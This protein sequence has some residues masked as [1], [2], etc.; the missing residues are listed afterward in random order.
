MPQEKLYETF[1][2][3]KT[4]D[5]Y[6]YS[7]KF[8]KWLKKTPIPNTKIHEKGIN[9]ECTYLQ[10][11]VSG[12]GSIPLHRF[13]FVWFNEIIEPYNENGELMDICHK[14]RDRENN[15]IDNLKWDTRKNNLA[16]RTGAINQYGRRKNEM[17]R[18][19]DNARNV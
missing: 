3:Y 9:K 13:V 6:Q 17:L 2:G 11:P 19:N 14:D 1:K 10:I 4:F 8:H 12:I 16:E 5:I 15:H 7:F 18:E